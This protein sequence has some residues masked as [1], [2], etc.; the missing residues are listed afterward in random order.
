V[1]SMCR[2]TVHGGEPTPRQKKWLRAIYARMPG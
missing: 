2:W 1:L